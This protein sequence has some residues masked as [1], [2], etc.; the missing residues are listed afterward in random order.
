[1]QV[2]LFLNFK[3]WKINFLVAGIIFLA[4]TIAAQRNDNFVLMICGSQAR[5]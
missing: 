2:V 3:Y 5:K 4:L 1:V